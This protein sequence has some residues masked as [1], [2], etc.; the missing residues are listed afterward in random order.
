MK[1]LWNDNWQIQT[2]IWQISELYFSSEC[3]ALLFIKLP[4]FHFLFWDKKKTLQSVSHFCCF[5]VFF[6]D[7][8]SRDV[9]FEQSKYKHA[10]DWHA[11]LIFSLLTN[12]HTW[13]HLK[14][15][16]YSCLKV[17]TGCTCSGKSGKWQRA[18]MCVCVC[19]SKPRGYFTD[20]L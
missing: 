8:P 15:I 11:V 20:L 2:D 17:H 4:V 1:C 13:S 10:I 5:V 9:L 14:I 18:E 12:T 19:V 16:A 3:Q 6:P 7:F